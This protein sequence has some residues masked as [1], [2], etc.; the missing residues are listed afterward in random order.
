MWLKVRAI[1]EYVY[2]NYRHDYDFFHIGGDDHY[3]IP[4][5]LKHVVTTGP[6]DQS[7]PLFLGGNMMDFPF[8]HRYCGG[9]SGYTMN[10]IALELLIEKLFGTHQCR[11]H[12][13][14]SDEDRI[15]SNCFRSVGIQCM[16]T[17]DE[18]QESRY[19][20][21]NVNF[22]ASWNH[23]VASV[24]RADSLEQVHGII[25][26]EGLGQ[27]SETSVSFHLKGKH[28][29]VQDRGMRRYYGILYGL[30]K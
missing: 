10:R 12:H 18:Q 7:A 21:A 24:W 1:W 8:K 13:V 14:A 20:Q 15:I 29:G 6:W 2:T 16:D 17:N 30:C 22:H 23:D 3:V 26:K 25:S 11:P 4:E 5:N 28:K 27:I 19:H 9:G